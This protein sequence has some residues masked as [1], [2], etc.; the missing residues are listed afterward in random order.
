M[1]IRTGK[2]TYFREISVGFLPAPDIRLAHSFD[3]WHAGPVVIHRGTKLVLVMQA[4]A[5]IFFQMNIMEADIFFTGSSLDFHK[6]AFAD[7]G[8]MQGNL[9]SF[10]EVGIK[11]IFTG[12]ITFRF[13]LA[14]SITKSES[15]YFANARIAP[16]D[17]R[18]YCFDTFTSCVNWTYNNLTGDNLGKTECEWLPCRTMCN[19]SCAIAYTDGTIENSSISS[20]IGAA[21]CNGGVVISAP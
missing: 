7:W 18:N 9:V 1:R 20:F 19:A 16:V 17:S 15:D 4:L 10:R 6:T 11:I 2:L 8:G 13:N 14:N 3:Q 5:R 21:N 12:K